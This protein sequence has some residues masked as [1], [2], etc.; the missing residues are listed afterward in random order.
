MEKNMKI[1]MTLVKIV[2]LPITFPYYILKWLSSGSSSKSE[3]TSTAN[4]ESKTGKAQAPLP[5]I[6]PQKGEKEFIDVQDVKWE[7]SVEIRVKYL[8]TRTKQSK[9]IIVPK[10]RKQ[11]GPLDLKW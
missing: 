3:T 5:V 6:T 2:L 11:T 1:I 7:S 8:D 4:S 9:S 10:G